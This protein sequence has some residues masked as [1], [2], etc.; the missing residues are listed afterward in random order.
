MKIVIAGGTGFCGRL[1]TAHFAACRHE[2]VILSR[3]LT[4]T[5]GAVT[6]LWDGETPGDWLTALEGADA[7]INLAGR[8]VNCRYRG[9]NC[10][11]IYASRLD[12]TRAIGEAIAACAAPPSVW[13]NASSATIYRYA[14]DR[15]MDEHS[16]EFGNGFSVDVCRRWERELFTASTPRTRRV[17]LRSAMVFGPEP[18]G[19]WDAFAELARFGLAGTMAGGRQFVSWIH[20][21]DFSRAIEWIIAHHDLCGPVNVAAPFPLPNRD[22]LRAVRRAIERPIGLPSARWMLEAGA[23]LKGTETELLLKSRRFVPD[24][25]LKSGFAFRYEHWP[26]AAAAIV[27]AGQ[28]TVRAG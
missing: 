5:P 27:K 28:K 23:W 9:D 15:E 3:C 18:G 12:S 8:S 11:A 25:L 7:V 17:A 20:S 19:V 16:G 13:L 21:E 22:F 26:D 6:M 10:A 14:E 4:Q 24:R 2:V 1:L